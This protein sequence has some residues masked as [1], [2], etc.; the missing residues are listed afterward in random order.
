MGLWKNVAHIK[1]FSSWR[2]ISNEVR[3]ASNKDFMPKLCPWEVETPIYPNRL[4]SFGNSS[5]RVRFLEVFGFQ[6][7]LNNK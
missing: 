3:C 5:P 1:I 6:L 7:F 4:L 2:D